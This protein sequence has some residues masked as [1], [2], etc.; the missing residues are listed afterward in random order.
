MFPYGATDSPQMAALPV[1]PNP[2]G[3]EIPVYSWADAVLDGRSGGWPSDIKAIYNLGTNYLS[4]GADISKNIRAFDQVD[5]VVCQ[6]L[7]LTPTARHSDVVLPPAH[8]LERSDMVT[9]VGGPYLLYST[10]VLPPRAGLPTDFQILSGLADRLSFG[11][12][13]TENRNQEDWLD[14]LIDRSEIDDPAEFKRTGIFRRTEPPRVGLDRFAADPRTNPLSTPS[15]LIELT[16]PDQTA[17]GFSPVPDNYRADD[18]V[19]FPFRLITPKIHHR[20]HSQGF[21]R[22]WTG[23]PMAQRLWLHP[24]DA[25][26]LGLSD[27]DAALVESRIGRGPGHGPPDRGYQAGGDL[28]G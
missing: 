16:G 21:N 13:F 3:V 2:A 20:V 26:K 23:S 27:G 6:D 10:Q 18:P 19:D 15:G 14:Y 22:D 24:V 25:A 17:A 11:P 28:P 8:F 9:P 1:P 12:D 5:L 7:F 4:Q